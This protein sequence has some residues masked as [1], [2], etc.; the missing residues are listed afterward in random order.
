M[1]IMFAKS[2]TYGLCNFE[3]GLETFPDSLWEPPVASDYAMIPHLVKVELQ[4]YLQDF[5]VHEKENIICFYIIV[6]KY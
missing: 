2:V 5:F 6:T 3:F 1:N 4:M